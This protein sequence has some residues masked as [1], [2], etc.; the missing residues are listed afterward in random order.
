MGEIVRWIPGTRFKFRL[1]PYQ[2]VA[3]WSPITHLALFGGVGIGKTFTGSHFAINQMMEWPFHTGFI[4]ANNYDQMSQATLRELFYWLDFYG[5]QWVIDKLPP[6]SWGFTKKAF[7]SYKN[8]LSVLH[9]ATGKPVHAFTRV[10]SEPN[11]LRG[12]EAS[13]YWIDETRDTPEETHNVLLGRLRES[14]NIRGIVTTTTNGQDWT[15]DRFVKGGD[16]K[17]YGSM[18]IPT[19]EAVRLGILTQAYLETMKRSYSPM[20]ALQEL[21]ALHVNVN[22]GRAYYSAGMRNRRRRAPWGDLNPN[23]SYPLIIGCDFNFSPSPHVWMVGQLGP[24]T[25]T[26]DWSRNIHWFGEL[27]RTE[28]STKEMARA[29]MAQWPDFFYR[30]FGDASGGVGTTSNAG[31]HDY[32]QMGHEFSDAGA[33]FSI[34][35]DQS[36]PL[37]RDRVENMNAKFCNAMGEI[38]QTYDPERCPMFDRDLTMVGWKPNVQRGR[39]KLDDGGDR[40]RTHASDGAGYAVWKL[41]PPARRGSI[42]TPVPSQFTEHLR[43]R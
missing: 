26:A 10:L 24:T 20:F 25:D 1:T 34:D 3:L 30:V 2:A 31:V 14:A 15:W 11:P 21:D 39:G 7:K 16:N 43:G 18:H 36:N 28:A 13:W 5:L 35:Y 27:C 19:A 29:I 40:N 22:T 23:P 8:V 12:F 32:N 38:T 17:L 4:G 33:Q 42:I 9:P 37:I 41:L 6:S